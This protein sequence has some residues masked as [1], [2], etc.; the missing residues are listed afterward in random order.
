[1]A[2]ADDPAADPKAHWRRCGRQKCQAG[3][4][5]CLLKWVNPRRQ[6]PRRQDRIINWVQARNQGRQQTDNR[7][8]QQRR[9]GQIRQAEFFHKRVN[10]PGW[11]QEIKH[12]NNAQKCLHGKNKTSQ[13]GYWESSLNRPESMRNTC[14]GN[15]SQV[16]GI[17]EM[18]SEWEFILRWGF[19][20][21]VIGGSHSGWIRDKPF[22]Q[23][24]IKPIMP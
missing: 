3:N 18:E 17:W 19:P 15:Q 4:T 10:S 22:L 11:Q 1:M 5:T 6:I 8:D 20:L 23:L 16:R 9:Q 7:T 13:W 24:P 12:G 21:V 14:A 2:P